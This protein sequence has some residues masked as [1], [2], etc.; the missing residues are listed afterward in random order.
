MEV[1]GGRCVEGDDLEMGV[2]SPHEPHQLGVA[3]EDHPVPHGD[4]EREVAAELDRVAEPLFAMDEDR[5]AG[6]REPIEEGAVGVALRRG[7]VGPLPAPLVFGEPF[8]VV[9]LQEE[10][11]GPVPVGLRVVR[12]EGEEVVADAEC[13][14]DRSQPHQ[15]RGE[16]GTGRRQGGIE[17]DG[18]GK[19]RDRFGQI[20]PGE[21]GDPPVVGE[22]RGIGET[23]TRLVVDRERL[24]V[25]PETVEGIPQQK[26]DVETL[27]RQEHQ[28]AKKNGRC[29]MGTAAAQLVGLGEEGIQGVHVTPR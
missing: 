3:L 24:V 10:E 13:L 25:S 8:P 27:G 4:D 6:D 26:P 11:K 23:G 12:V 16:G 21:E 28:L 20:P 29:R 18:A 17:D 2:E 14:V 9:P 1:E 15:R 5:P 19:G 22:K 7:E